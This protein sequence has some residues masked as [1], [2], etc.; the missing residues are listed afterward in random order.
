MKIS[1]RYLYNERSNSPIEN[2]LEIMYFDDYSYEDIE[3][4][5][6]EERELID[7]IIKSLKGQYG[8]YSVKVT[9]FSEL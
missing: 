2:G 7:L 1:V 5:T 4:G 6:L 8:Y 9:S 3:D